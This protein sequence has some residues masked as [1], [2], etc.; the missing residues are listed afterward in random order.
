MNS[1]PNL[2]TN[3]VVDLTLLL[4]EE[5][6]CSWPGHMPYQQK[7]FNYFADGGTDEARFQSRCG[8]YQTRWLLIDEHTGTHMDA[9]AHFIPREG[10]GLPD[11]SAMGS[12]TAEQIDLSQLIGPAVVIDVSDLLGGEQ[13]SGESPDILPDHVV[14]HEREFGA[15]SPGDIVLFRSNWDEKY[16]VSGAAGRGYAADALLG[17]HGPAWPAPTAETM[18][19]L[20]DRGVRCIGTDGASMGSS[21]DGRGVHIAGFGQGAVFIE[22][23][24]NLRALPVLGATFVFAPLKVAR[25]SGAPGRAFAFLP[26]P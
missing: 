10:L 7:T 22:A 14:Q 9:P 24:G 4:A 16:Y 21:H 11:E 3:K 18:H 26:E 2:V 19:H 23:L 17:G 25:G 20:I 5:L 6:P 12:V 8:N 15:I 1:S 13:V